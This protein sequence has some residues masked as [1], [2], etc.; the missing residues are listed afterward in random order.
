MNHYFLLWYYTRGLLASF[1]LVG[2]L[3]RYIAH[4]FHILGLLATLVA[5]WKRD[6]TFRDWLGFHPIKSLQI[7][8][9]NLISR[10]LGMIVRLIVITGGTIVLI[11]VT[12]FGA[13]VFAVYV[14]APLLLLL[15]GVF[16][17]IN[18][19]LGAGLLFGGGIGVI[20]ALIGYLSRESEEEETTDITLL[21]KKPW[22]R[23]LL[24]RLGL[25][26]KEL[27]RTMLSDTEAF[28]S[29][30]LARGV[31]EGV[32]EQAVSLEYQASEES[33]RRSALFSWENLHKS[34]PMGKWWRYAYTP[35]LDQ[36][37][38]DLSLH[39]PTQYASATLIGREEEY[40]MTTLVLERPS[41]N[42]V[43]LVGDPGIGKKILIHQLARLIRENAFEGTPL[44]E[45]RVV[46][47]DI[48]RV[49]SDAVTRGEDVDATV[50][51][52]LGEATYAGNIIVVI[53][54][55]DT[56]LGD[57][58]S[59]HN[60]APVLG[61]FLAFPNFRLIATMATGRFHALAQDYAGLLKF[62]ETIYFH[63]TTE[64][65]TLLVLLDFVRQ[66]ERKQVVFTL[67][68]LLSIITQSSRYKWEVPFPERALDL[69]EETL[70]Y[71]QGNSDEAFVTPQTVEAFVSL[72]TGVP[73]GAIGSDEKDKLLRLEELLH[74]RVIGQ[75]EA[76]KQVAE[77]MRRARA[78]FGD[79]KRPLGSFIFL[80]PTGVGKT[81][82]VK[83]FAES[84]FGDE[85]RMIRL[86]M[87]EYQTPEAVSRLIGSEAIGV[88]GQLT[89]LVKEKPF[90]I[91]LLDEL[92]KAYPKALDLFL[93][94]LDEGFVTDSAGEKISF[95]NT[96]IIATSNAGAPLIKESLEQGMPLADVRKRVMD[97]IVEQG[98]YRLE[99]L[100]RFD[101]VIFFEPLSQEELLQVTN[102]KLESFSARL[103]KEKN[104]TI[105]FAPGVAEKIVAK[106]Y[107]PEFGAR[108]I[109]RYIEDTI[110]DVVIGQIIAGSATAGSVLSVTADQL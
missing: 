83:A 107:Q 106:G 92:E 110:E 6:V 58:A 36:Y 28:K 109:N 21:Q 62:F 13:M 79:A 48:G 20:G 12:M 33:H 72:Q 54:N 82:T 37:G 90:S 69:A 29:F 16:L 5:P 19:L 61:E 57:G 52:L 96:I 18:P 67:P 73:T 84:Y 1:F 55:L 63:E 97:Y 104:I 22:F 24:G 49:V 11:V 17:F 64:E 95:R 56:V 98:I 26:K 25:N 44:G 32:Y 50:R 99:F 81:E 105:E 102:M 43:L 87:S 31:Q 45:S 15:G 10:F 2:T 101:G 65:E 38:L 100:N 59:H 70:T 47:L 41:Q 8:F 75:D 80:G 77:A 27:D 3:S 14:T 88:S 39:D 7:L 60:L 51:Q 86:D 93:Q 76:V 68:A 66:L 30:L 53:E 40:K 9:E 85:T 78:G 71:W 34:S 108:S 35:H 23:K 42:S 103:K 74:K 89:D 94:I 91:L 4:R 46:L